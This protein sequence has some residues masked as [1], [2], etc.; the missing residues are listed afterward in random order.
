MFQQNVAPELRCQQ[1]DNSTQAVDSGLP[2]GL[3][4]VVLRTLARTFPVY[5]QKLSTFL[6]QYPQLADSHNS[7]TEELPHVMQGDL[8][9][10]PE[11]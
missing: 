1:G 7:H 5:R 6:K 2:P 10:T 4:L 8:F 3:R 11:R 9:H